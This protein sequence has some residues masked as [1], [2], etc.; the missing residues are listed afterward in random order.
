MALWLA[1]LWVIVVVLG[2]R[3]IREIDFP[4]EETQQPWGAPAGVIIKIGPPQFR[5]DRSAR[6]LLYRGSIDRRMKEQLLE[7]FSF[8]EAAARRAGQKKKNNK[9]PIDKKHLDKNKNHK[10]ERVEGKGKEEPQATAAEDDVEL[11]RRAK[12]SYY[13]AIDAL[14][15]RSNVPPKIDTKLFLYLGGLCGVVGV[16]IRSLTTFIWN[17]VYENDIDAIKGWPWW[18]MRPLLGFLL[19]VV[20]IMLVKAE[21]FRPEGAH[22]K[23]SL[24][25]WMGLASLVGFGAI[26]FT[27]RLR[28]ATKALFGGKS[29]AVTEVANKKKPPADDE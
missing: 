4:D 27:E 23:Q 26:D 15:Y 29:S 13:D 20:V 24:W 21:L 22:E 2:A 3:A 17:T 6:R 28:N 5:Y 8:D 7:L 1:V 16:L 11:E 18:V 14:A 9:P 10:K 19:G 25:W 12:L